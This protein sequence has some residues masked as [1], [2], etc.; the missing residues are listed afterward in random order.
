MF[1][2]LTNLQEKEKF[3]FK[4][5]LMNYNNVIKVIYKREREILL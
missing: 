5:I 4:V 2:K 3:Y 1:S